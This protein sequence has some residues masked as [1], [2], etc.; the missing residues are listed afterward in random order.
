MKTMCRAQRHLFS[1][2]YSPFQPRHHSL[3]CP[4]LLFSFLFSFIT[5][6]IIILWF[7]F[8]LTFWNCL[9]SFT[10]FSI[11]IILLKDELNLFFWWIIPTTDLTETILPWIEKD[12]ETGEE[13]QYNEPC[14]CVQCSSHLLAFLSKCNK[15]FILI[16]SYMV[17]MFIHYLWQ[18]K[19]PKQYL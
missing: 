19:F 4:F 6:Y 7:E 5:Y 3:M 9:W 12:V 17:S 8:K 14:A 11:P 16:L 10:P 2:S 15:R 18:N 1:F 13:S